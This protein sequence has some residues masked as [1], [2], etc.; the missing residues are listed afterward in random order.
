LLGARGPAPCRN[1]TPRCPGGYRKEDRS[2]PL[3]RGEYQP[4]TS[5]KDGCRIGLRCGI[6]RI[7]PVD[8]VKMRLPSCPS[9]LLCV[10]RVPPDFR[11]FRPARSA[12]QGASAASVV[13]P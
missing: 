8:P 1:H 2:L 7:D 11:V 3:S 4:I 9:C 13:L 6:V 10:L 12:T 5:D